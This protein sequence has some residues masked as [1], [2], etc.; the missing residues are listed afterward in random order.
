MKNIVINGFGRIGRLAFR[1]LVYSNEYKVVGINSRS[2]PDELA[3]LLKYD[4]VYRTFGENEISFNDEGIIFDGE[5]IKTYIISEDEKFPWKELNVDCVLE[6]SGAYTKL[7]KAMKHIEDGAKHVVISAPGKGEMKTIVY[8][9]NHE[10]INGDEEVISASSC[11]TN[12][13]A[14]VVNLIH[15]NIGI[16]SGYMTTIHA[17][18]N[19]QV[20]LD[21][22]HDKGI[23][24]RRGRTASQN[25]IPTSTGAASS[26]SKVIPKLAG[27]L[28]GASLRVPVIDGSMVDLTLN[29]VKET[30]IEELN[31]L[32]KNNQNSVLKYTTDP[33]VSSDIIGVSCGALVDGKLTNVLENNKKLVKIVAWYDNE[34]GYTAQM[35]RAMNYLLK[36]STRI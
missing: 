13:L 19:D 22:N 7:E 11:T 26:I 4:T 10:I 23:N 29:L 3:Y 27:I 36:K 31:N 35:L 2:N 12:C 8:G 1:E 17:I 33:I 21:G 16:D 5:L 30:S 25:I 24:S 28:D 18:T 20:T 32:F 34:F 9:V 6:C 15:Q 14:P